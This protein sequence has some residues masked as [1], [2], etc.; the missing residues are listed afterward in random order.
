MEAVHAAARIWTKTVRAELQLILI[1]KDEGDVPMM[2]PPLVGRAHTYTVVNAI[3]DATNQPDIYHW[4]VMETKDGGWG[5]KGP[6]VVDMAA[7]WFRDNPEYEIRGPCDLVQHARIMKFV[8]VL[9]VLGGSD[10]G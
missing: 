6:A 2:P 10:C 4:I 1:A 8:E 7:Q 3:F 5:L 9:L